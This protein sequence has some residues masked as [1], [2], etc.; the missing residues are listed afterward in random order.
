MTT[1]FA[2]IALSRDRWTPVN[3]GGSGFPTYRAAVEAIGELLAEEATF[4]LGDPDAEGRYRILLDVSSIDLSTRDDLLAIMAYDPVLRTMFD[5][6]R[7]GGGGQTP[8]EASR[9]A[10]L[11]GKPPVDK[12]AGMAGRLNALPGGH[13]DPPDAVDP[14]EAGAEVQGIV[15]DGNERRFQEWLFDEIQDRRGDENF[16]DRLQERIAADGPLLERMAAMDDMERRRAKKILMD[17]TGHMVAVEGIVEGETVRITLTGEQA[18]LLRDNTPLRV[19][20]GVRTC[21]ECGCTEDD[22]SGCIERTGVRCSWVEQDLCS[23]CVPPTPYQDTDIA[24][25]E[26]RPK[27]WRRPAT[28]P[29]DSV[30]R[31]LADR[32]HLTVAGTRMTEDEYQQLASVVIGCHREIEAA[33]AA[34]MPGSKDDAEPTDIAGAIATAGAKGR[35]LQALHDFKPL[36]DLAIDRLVVNATKS[37]G[38]KLHPDSVRQLAHEAYGQVRLMLQTLG[39]TEA[40]LD[41]AQVSD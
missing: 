10:Q 8:E 40:E 12:L 24:N 39:V 21:R 26:S 7:F 37:R 32:L 5:F 2:S 9:L 33:A 17:D 6:G 14:A 4:N 30:A 16:M 1:Y 35:R 23:A 31:A 34:L 18:A 3:P 25:R 15:H 28:G 19:S 22:C 38:G 11:A 41:E 20:I 13:T 29:V 27:W 36:M